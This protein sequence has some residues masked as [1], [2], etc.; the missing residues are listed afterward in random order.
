MIGTSSP[1]EDNVYATPAATP[2]PVPEGEGGIQT[3]PG[4]LSP[5]DDSH[6][7]VSPKRKVETM[8]PNCLLSIRKP[9]P[10]LDIVVP[11]KTTTNGIIY[12]HPRTLTDASP[13]ASPG[14]TK[15][16]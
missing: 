13:V 8:E 5:V 7:R 4:A 3:S 1:A 16:W 14:G 6:L 15:P 2:P 12:P 10:T 9:V 11:A